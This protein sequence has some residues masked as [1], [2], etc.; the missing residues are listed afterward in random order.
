[1]DTTWDVIVVGGSAAG[2]SAALTLGRSRR[3]VLVVDGGRP[4]NRFATHVHGVLG[5]EG[6]PPAEL[7][8][9]A[10]EETAGY[11][12][13]LRDGTVTAVGS[14][15]ATLS[16]A[17]AEGSTLGARTVLLA[18]G[19]TDVLP[20]VPGLAAHWGTSVLHCPYCHGWEVRD[21]RLGV[22]L[23]SPLALHQVQLVRQLSAD[24]VA[25]TAGLGVV[26]P[27]I[28]RRL[29]ARGV[30]LVPA[31]VVEVLGED[32][33][34][35]GV[36]TEGGDVV[37]VEAIFTAPTPLPH[38]DVVSGLG[39]ARTERAG[40]SVLA[41]DQLGQTSDHRVWAAGNVVDPSLNVVG[42]A[43]G[44]SVAGAAINLA[45]AHADTDAAVGARH[46]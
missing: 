11:G 40:V 24:V 46:G 32:G 23:T 1:M 43:S 6:R 39:L 9:A 21:R 5:H 8:A 22:L 44:G 4:R 12:V 19:I 28:E 29:L 42:S 20:D 18:T 17:T 45:L 3:R 34:L 27:G 13:V 2:L 7:L 36:R 15:G 30:E 35:T 37:A 25:F 33:R 38:D 16:V 26:E 41:V 31:P 10:R 14:T